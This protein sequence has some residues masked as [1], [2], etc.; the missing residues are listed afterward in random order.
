MKKI[1]ATLVLSAAIPFAGAA[2][3]QELPGWPTNS[4]CS[5][6]DNACPAFE[7]EYRG[8]VSGVWN[9]LPPD[10]RSTCVSETAAF[11][12]SYRLLYDCLANKMQENMKGQARGPEGGQVVN[13]TPPANIPEPKAPAE[14]APATPAETAP[15]ATPAPAEATTAAPAEPAPAQSAAPAEATPA[16]P[17]ETAPAQSATPAA[18]PEATPAEPAAPAEPA[19]AQTPAAEPAKPQ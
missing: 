17:P 8:Q 11:E 6:G 4:G 19:P 13:M 12:K 3:A 9:T 16:A 1:I 2:L 7:S 15:A 5:A 10:V 14:A 18:P